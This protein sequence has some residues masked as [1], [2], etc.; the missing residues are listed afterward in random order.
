MLSTEQLKEFGE[1]GYVVVPGVV[2]RNVVAKANKRIDELIAA[3]PP[4]QGQ[5]GHHFY[6]PAAADEPELLETLMDSA[7]GYAEALTGPGLLETPQQVQVALNIPPFSHR[8]GRPHIDAAI[9]E[10]TPGFTPNSFTLLA[11]VFVTDQLREN[12]G[13]LW[14]WPGTHRTHAEYFRERGIEM[15]CAYPDIELPEPEQVTARAGDLLLAHYLLGHNI[16][17]N[18]ESDTTRRMLYYRVSGRGHAEGPERILT[19][20]WYEYGPVRALI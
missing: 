10:P 15:Y 20:P 16:G 13:N 18:Y 12:S 2:A 17:G 1:R 5:V 3:N 8:P 4:A 6:F 11:G 19:E 14:V 9:S 7:F